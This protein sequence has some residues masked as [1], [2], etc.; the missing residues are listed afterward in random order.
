MRCTCEPPTRSRRASTAAAL[1]G[2]REAAVDVAVVEAGR[3]RR[4][5]QR[6]RCR[7]VR[8]TNVAAPAPHAPARR[9]ARAD[10]CSEAR[11]PHPGRAAGVRRAR[12]RAAPRSAPSRPTCSVLWRAPARGRRDPGRGLAPGRSGAANAALAPSARCSGSCS[13]STRPP[14]SR[15]SAAS[16]C[17]VGLQLVDGDLLLLLDGAHNPAGMRRLGGRPAPPARG[18]AATRGGARGAGA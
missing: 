1:L 16:A 3:P 15:R 4:R 10:R 13:P 14:L 7:I 8:P 9:H 17:W 6:A 11:R 2:F 18:A 5:H 12:R